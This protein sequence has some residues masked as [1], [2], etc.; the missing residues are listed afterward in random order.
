MHMT[1]AVAPLRGSHVEKKKYREEMAAFI[2]CSIY[3][4]HNPFHLRDWWWCHRT[5][6]WGPTERNIFIFKKCF[7]DISSGCPIEGR[8]SPHTCIS[9]SFV[10]SAPPL[11]KLQTL[12]GAFSHLPAHTLTFQLKTSFLTPSCWRGVKSPNILISP[13]DSEITRLVLSGPPTNGKL[14]TEITRRTYQQ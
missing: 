8:N 10:Q 3:R 9:S 7:R 6:V 11:T 5:S 4:H 2:H 1:A 12:P 14:L 13:T